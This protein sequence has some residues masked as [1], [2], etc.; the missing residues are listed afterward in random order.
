LRIIHLALGGCLRAPP[1]PYGLTADTGGHIAYVLEA[2][3]AQALRSDVENVTIVT[4]LFDDAALGAVHAEPFEPLGPKL[5]IGRIA[6]TRRAYLEK[7]E[8]DAELPALSRSFLDHVSRYRPNVVHAHFADAVEVASPAVKAL[9]IPLVYTPHSLGLDRYGSSD[10][11]NP[12]AVARFAR[13]RC[14]IA[15]ADRIIV[16]TIDEA[17]CQVGGYEVPGAAPRL[18]CVAPGIPNEKVIA[19]CFG[20]MRILVDYLEDPVR[21]IVLAIA[22]PVRRK[23]L[24]AVIEAFAGHGPLRSIANL[25]VLAGL[26]GGD[27]EGQAIRQELEMSVVQNGLVGRV[28]L[29]PRH[30]TVELKGLYELATASGGVFVNAALHEPFGLTLLEAARAGLPVVATRC[31]GAAEVVGR[32]GHGLLIDPTDPA[33]I[34]ACCWRI[35][36]QPTFAARLRS[37]GRRRVDAF[38]WNAYALHTRAIYRAAALRSVPQTMHCETM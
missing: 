13:E 22:R 31:G 36:S 11:D 7:G 10:L 25:V 15:C 19:D 38:S 27:P 21:P 30:T 3:H 34:A 28:A 16:S 32:L 2:A 17:S 12:H 6:G 23:N 20:A 4:R 29:P 1:V 18:H 35:V 37:S 5:S 8:L 26:H 9:S 24:P 33:Q 14:A